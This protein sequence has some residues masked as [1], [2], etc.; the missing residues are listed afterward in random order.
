MYQVRL[1]IAVSV[2]S[3]SGIVQLQQDLLRREKW[4]A[5]DIKAVDKQSLRFTLLFLGEIGRDQ[6]GKIK[7]KLAEIKF[8]P[9]RLTFTGV[10]GFPEPNSASTIWVGVDEKG[11]ADLVKL[12][13]TVATKMKEIDLQPDK[14]FIPRVTIF[15][16]RA[17][18]LQAGKLFA[19]YMNKT[20]G[21]D[22]VDKVH[23]TKSEHGASG[24][25]IYSNILTV[26]ATGGLHSPIRHSS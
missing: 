14:P 25:Q 6:V 16:V 15:N 20:F 11:A 9:F 22:L 26:N 19:N 7:A 3:K 23:L 13:S 1:F 21:S 24:T 17:G 5:G 8:L 12:A 10:G 18:R 2:A 4:D